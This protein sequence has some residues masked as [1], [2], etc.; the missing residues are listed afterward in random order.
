[1]AKASVEKEQEVLV[2]SE[3]AEGTIQGE[4][5]Q[6]HTIVGGVLEAGTYITND[7]VNIIKPVDIGEELVTLT[8][9]ID[10]SRPFDTQISI[11]VN[12]Q[13]VVVQRG[14]EVTIQRKF[15]EA[16]NNAE[17]QRGRAVAM[18]YSLSNDN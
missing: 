9:P 12:G 17:A 8:I 11:Q 18:M 3:L 5:L 10:Y 2:Q 15:A 1:M 4:T 13:T 16:Y 7:A 14:I 6:G